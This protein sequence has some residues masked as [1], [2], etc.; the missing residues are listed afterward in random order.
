MKITPFITGS[1]MAGQGMAKALGIIGVINPDFQIAPYVKVKRDQSLM[2]LTKGVENPLLLLGSPHGYHAEQILEGEKAGFNWIVC[3][4]PVC[5]KKDDIA[6]LKNVKANVAVTHGFRQNWGPQTMKKMI[7]AGEFGEIISIEG[8]YWQSSAAAA[9]LAGQTSS[10]KDWKND[11][12]LNGPYDAMVDLGAH[13]T[14]MMFFFAGG[15]PAE[16]RAWVSHVNAPAAHRDTHAHL[17]FI[18][19]K[20]R[21]RGS[22]S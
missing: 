14:D 11:P 19:P 4:K 1:G 21:A 15:M 22:I 3:D 17:E 2:G 8:R 9:A 7:D 10:S 12:K 13:Y 16:T 20:F 18:F 6:R 5:I